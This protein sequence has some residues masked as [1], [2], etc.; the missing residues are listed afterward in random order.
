MF[1][2]QIN[3]IQFKN[4]RTTVRQFL[5]GEAM[6]WVI[7]NFIK[8]KKLFWTIWNLRRRGSKSATQRSNEFGR[9]SPGDCFV[10]GCP[11]QKQDMVRHLRVF[12]KDILAK[13]RSNSAS[14]NFKKSADEYE[15]NHKRELS[16]R[17]PFLNF[18]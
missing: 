6:Q 1:P 8:N 13:R 9:N 12:F 18:S 11:P 16:N 14:S 10:V 17:L 7:N 15:Q 2:S 3:S 4:W 5:R